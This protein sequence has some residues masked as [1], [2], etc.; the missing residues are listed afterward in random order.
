M[1]K[2]LIIGGSHRDI[3]LIN[4]YK[5]LGYYTITLGNLDYYIGHNYSDKNFK[6]DFRDEEQLKV[7]MKNESI[8]YIVPG[9]GELPM[10]IAA[11]VSNNSYYDSMEI[12][13]TLHTKNLFKDLCQDI[14]VHVPFGISYTSIN[15]AINIPFPVIVKPLNLSGGRGISIANDIKELNQSIRKAQNESNNATVLIEEFI[16]SDLFAYSVIF[17]NQKILYSFTAQEIEKNYY[18]TT[19]FRS[20]L[21]LQLI[22]ILNFDLEKIAKKLALKDGLL[23]VQ[24]MIKNNIAHI[25]EVTRRIP[26]DLFPNMID[27]SDGV[28]YSKAVAKC[29]LG[30]T[31][32]IDK[33]LVKTKN[34]NLLRYCIVS[35]K[36]CVFDDIFID[37][38][39]E[40]LEKVTIY[41]KNDFVKANTL[42]AI[43]IIKFNQNILKNI[44]KLIYVKGK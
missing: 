30:E 25:L 38:N 1:K 34:L 6:I 5:E 43:V 8:D 12:L 33:M 19:T 32:D 4:A 23:H 2:I 31:E 37:S 17:K 41:N 13:K 15:N 3:P 39:I 9:S 36:E 40:I 10:L 16:D 22:E 21:N 29:Y 24:F 18:V 28:S 27:M 14:G 44:D 35:K 7:I 42:V 26:G 11:K 20:N